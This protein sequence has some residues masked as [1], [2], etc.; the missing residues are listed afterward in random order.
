MKELFTG[1][2]ALLIN[3]WIYDFAAYD[4]WAKPLGLLQIGSLLRQYGCS[5]SLIDCLGEKRSNC[6][7][8]GRGKY[9]KSLAEKPE[10]L[11]FFEWGYYRY[12]I[13]NE[14]FK[15][16]LSLIESPDVILISSL[17]TYWYP[18]VFEAIRI[19]KDMFGD[20]PVILGGVYATL[21]PAHAKAHSGADLIIEGDAR[22][23]ALEALCSLWCIKYDPACFESAPMPA[24]YPCFDLTPSSY[25]CIA[26]S[27]GCPY[28]CTYCA[29]RKLSG[30]FS[31]RDPLEVADEVAYWHNRGISDFAF[32]DDALL[33]EPEKMIIPF[34]NRIIS[35]GIDVSFHCP[36]G[37]HAGSISIETA[38][39]MKKSGFK[40]IR[41]GFE[42]ADAGLQVSTGGKVSSAQY[43]K[44]VNNLHSEGYLSEEIGVYILCGLPGQHFKQV[45]DSVDFVA[46]SGAR[47]V[48]TEYSPIPSTA[49]WEAAVASSPFPI[50][51]D[52]LFHNNTLI[53]CR[54]EGFTYEMYRKLRSQLKQRRQ[55]I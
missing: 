4:M 53:P 30:Q 19:V 54:W 43:L 44:A 48:L 51:T 46:A 28:N 31:R 17:M 34:M 13:S 37:L 23:K 7:S 12:G 29:S 49:L 9:A 42:T 2:K 52:P 3:P 20:V 27:K 25:V 36:N 16:R 45:E 35:M 26:A 55:D 10:A 32:Y 50:E 39:L 41:L 1:K 47:P 6:K 14:E 18:G 21:C 5:V 15:T 33:F 8:D 24:P 22:A 11:K 38:G 40:T